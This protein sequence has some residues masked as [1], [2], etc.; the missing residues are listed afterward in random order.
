MQ[1][2]QDLEKIRRWCIRR[3]IDEWKVTDICKH[4]HI[5]RMSFYRYWNR[6]KKEGLDGLK[7]HSKRP[8][9]IHKTDKKIEQ[10][11]I[12]LRR[13]KYT[14]TVHTRYRELLQINT[15]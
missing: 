15:T 7:D 8:H 11:V 3:K 14:I 10:K 4:I 12:Q 6:Y 9:T 5:S 2:K 1:Y 13:K